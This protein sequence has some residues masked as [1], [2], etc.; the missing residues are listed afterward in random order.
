MKNDSF[1]EDEM[2]ALYV[3]DL[4]GTLFNTEK[5]VSSF[6]AGIINKFII[7]GGLFTSLRLE[8]GIWLRL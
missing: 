8:N 5:K 2:K 3:S 1:R 4:D 7:Q 6:S